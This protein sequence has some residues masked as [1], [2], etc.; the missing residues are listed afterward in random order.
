VLRQ[1][2]LDDRDR[3]GVP[4]DI[5]NCWRTDNPDQ[6]NS[7]GDGEGDA[8]SEGEKKRSS[9]QRQSRP[10]PIGNY[11]IDQKS[12][13]E[14]IYEDQRACNEHTKVAAEMQTHQRPQL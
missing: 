4:D 8:C 6:A 9:Y 11:I 13:Y 2:E 14:R 3:D 10:A 7:D 1:D 5:D 12:D